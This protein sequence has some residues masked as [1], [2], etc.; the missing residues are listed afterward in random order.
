MSHPHTVAVGNTDYVFPTTLIR[1]YCPLQPNVTHYNPSVG[2][3]R[4]YGQ[5]RLYGLQDV[6]YSINKY[7]TEFYY[8][9]NCHVYD[10]TKLY[11]RSKNL[12]YY[13]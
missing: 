8:F 9:G 10:Q 2:K 6:Y 1:S 11:T 12:T 13:D 4:H 3:E 5:L 7:S